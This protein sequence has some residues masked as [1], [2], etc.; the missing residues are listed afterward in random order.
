MK[1]LALPL[2]ATPHNGFSEG[3]VSVVTVDS[4]RRRWAY[5]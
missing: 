5:R 2:E 3:V 4:W 1:N